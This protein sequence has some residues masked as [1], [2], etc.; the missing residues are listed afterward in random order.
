MAVIYVPIRTIS[1]QTGANPGNAYWTKY[2]WPTEG[3][4][5]QMPATK[6]D[7]DSNIYGL[8]LIPANIK[9][10]S[11]GGMNPEI[12][13]RWMTNTSAGGVN[14]KFR[15]AWSAFQQT[16]SLSDQSLNSESLI[17]V[18]VGGVGTYNIQQFIQ[19]L[20]MSPA[21]GNLPDTAGHEMFIRLL[22]N[23]ADAVDTVDIV[24]YLDWFYVCEI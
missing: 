8:L 4:E 23:G 21:T 6:A 7:V 20:T 15:I 22:R 13:V 19:A 10:V 16:T 1:L 14:A 24:Y 11:I 12:R 5:H 3:L 17:T 9:P 2:T 18:G